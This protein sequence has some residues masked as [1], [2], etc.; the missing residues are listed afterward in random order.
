[1]KITFG[2]VECNHKD[3][4]IHRSRAIKRSLKA[5]LRRAFVSLW[6]H[7]VTLETYGY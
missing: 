4:K 7:N 1:M 5:H 3:T 2:N 6:L